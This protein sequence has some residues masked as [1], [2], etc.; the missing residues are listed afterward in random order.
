MPSIA[1]ANYKNS[2]SY[3]SNNSSIM[4]IEFYIC[5]KKNY[6]KKKN[7]IKFNLFNFLNFKNLQ[8]YQ[9]N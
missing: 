3:Y 5:F 6:I 2:C 7:L 9:F 4:M 8:I 1:C